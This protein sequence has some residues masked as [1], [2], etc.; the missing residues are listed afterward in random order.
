MAIMLFEWVFTSA[1][2]ILVVLAL[3]AALG[4]RM[5]AGLRYGL[6]AVV[7]VRLL[8]PVQLFT[9]PIVGTWVVTEKRTERTVDNVE[10][11]HNPNEDDILDS[12]GGQAGPSVS[13]TA[14]PQAPSVPNMPGAPEPPAPPDLTRAPAWLGWAWLAGS[15]LAALVLLASN[16][17]F[18]RRLRRERIPLEEAD[19][20]LRVFAAAGLPS[21]CLFGI[22]RPAVYVTPDAAADPDMLRHVLA[23]E[24]THYRHG[25]HIWSLLRCAALAAHWW[26]PLVWLAAVLSQRDGELACDE[27]ALKRL[28]DRE[29]AA[30]GSTL[31]ALVTAKPRPGDLF[32]CATTMVGDKKSLRERVS[33]I[34]C[35]PKRVVWAV[36]VAVMVTALASLCAFGQAEPEPEDGPPIV[37][38][39]GSRTE[40][41]FSLEEWGRYRPE[42]VVQ[43]KGTVEGFVLEGETEWYPPGDESPLGQVM[44]TILLEDCNRPLHVS[45]G[46]KDDGRTS[47]E[48]SIEHIGTKDGSAFVT[49]VTFTATRSK[50]GWTVT[51]MEGQLPKLSDDR[52]K[53]KV[54][55]E[56]A[57]LLARIAAT[58]LTEAEEYYNSEDG[59]DWPA[60]FPSSWKDI[61]TQVLNI[62]GQDV[63]GKYGQFLMDL[64]SQPIAAGNSGRPEFDGWRVKTVD[65]P[66][67]STALGMD[68]EIWRG[69]SE[70]HTP[71][72]EKAKYMLAGGM[73]VT[74]DGWFSP[75]DRWTYY[76]FSLDPDGRRFAVTMPMGA[77]GGAPDGETQ[78][79]RDNFDAMVERALAD[80]RAVN[81][82][83]LS[84]DLNRNGIPEE[85]R[86]GYAVSA[87]KEAGRKLE[88][89]EDGELIYEEEGYFAHAGY[90]ALFLYHDDDGDYLLRYNPYMAQGWA[91]YSYRLFTLN[92][93]GAS[94][95]RYV[96]LEFDLNFY[97]VM[98]DSHQFDV[99]E[100]TRFMNE[101][102]ELLSHSVQLINTDEDLLAT[103]ERNGRLYDDLGWL[104]QWEPIYV[105]GEKALPDELWRFQSAMEQEWYEKE[106]VLTQVNETDLPAVFDLRYQDRSTRF[107]VD[108][109][110]PRFVPTLQVLDWNGDGKD[111]IV[112]SLVSGSGTGVLVEDLYV[113]D[114]DTLEQYD[115]SGV[116]EMI[117]NAVKST[118]DEENFY[119]RGAGM[120]E[121][122]PKSGAR[123]EN[124]YAPVADALWFEDQVRWTVKDD[125]VFCWLGCD[126]SG[127]LTNYIGW[128]KV[129]VNMSPSGAFSCGRALYAD[130][131]DG[132]E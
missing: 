130:L 88:V 71:E 13:L 30:Y 3:R 43:M 39:T 11:F 100:I 132:P 91:T 61:P 84:P 10:K 75:E 24:Y 80:T 117:F 16:L 4:K 59:V 115:T 106:P 19:L 56:E 65:G 17:R 49:T 110:D 97:P 107:T 66:W 93:H 121:T 109:A 51:D 113:F 70:Y 58:L 23:H 104:D 123:E 96:D 21:P 41:T 87:D 64:D 28:G 12:L 34:A 76:I 45:A 27:G 29:R 94:T 98:K 119:L 86:V 124:E 105:R 131:A 125:Q 129:P 63:R 108:C 79:M 36:V 114:A 37:S 44:M 50:E 89:W 120:D 73:Y 14:F 31:L 54:T 52:P 85:L 42:P 72:P 116:S 7:L 122:I 32:R 9:S 35:A 5:S 81:P 103:F 90:N 18:Y 20:P 48:I 8:V 69:F 126:A 92:E 40:L 55:D 101:I 102:N 82:S 6:W 38:T 111:E 62:I 60:H 33:R 53:R 46:W 1:F 95:A 78:Q 118:G 112:F 77:G 68:L 25:D 26:N 47:V 22:L 57:V 83:G 128:V 67:T 74:E 2:L 15:G 99:N 127:T